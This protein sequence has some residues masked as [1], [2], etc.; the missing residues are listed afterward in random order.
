MGKGNSAHSGVVEV[1]IN[2]EIS[3]SVTIA[4]TSIFRGHL[5]STELT[6]LK[7]PVL[8]TLSQQPPQWLRS[9]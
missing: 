6:D 7:G 4:P 8:S 3:P 9:R 1:D 5:N 2:L